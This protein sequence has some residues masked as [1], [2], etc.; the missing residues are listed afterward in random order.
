[1]KNLL[2]IL[3]L[4]SFGSYI[5][6]QQE[7]YSEV[8]IY[9]D[10]KSLADLAKLG[11]AVEEGQYLKGTYFITILSGKELKKITSSGFRYDILQ[12]DY[13]NFI[14]KRNQGSLQQIKE[15]NINKR[16]LSPKSSSNY[17]VPQG[18][19]LGSMGG[20]YTLAEANA[21]LDSLS[22]KYPNLCAARM[23]ATL[24][25][26]IEGRPV[27]YV[28]ISKDTNVWEN[29]PKILYDGLT[30]SREPI[31]MQELFFYVNY[32][33]E[34]YNTDPEIQYMIDNSEIYFIPVVNPDGY[35]Y[36][37]Y[38]E[39]NG[40][41]MWRKNRRNNGG[42]Q[43]G[44]DLNRNFGFKW[45]YDNIGSSPDSSTDTYRG[46]TAFSEPETQIIRDFCT[47][48]HISSALNDHSYA[49]VF[50]Y[51]W[52]Y[53]TSDTPDSLLQENFSKVMVQDNQLIY[54]TPGAVLYNTNGDANDWMYGDQTL[55]PKIFAFTPEI[56][57]GNDGFWPS[58]DDIIPLC[59]D[60]M[61]MNL[62]ATKLVLKYAQVMDNSP[63]I[64]A[65][66]QGYI[67]FQIER[68]GLDS[69]GIYNVSIQSLD[70]KIIPTGSARIFQNM[71][72]FQTLTD[73]ISYMLVPGITNGTTIR[74]L[75]QVNNGYYT[76]SDTIT[77]WYGTPIT[78]FSDSCNNLNNWISQQW[79]IT[80]IS[81]HTPP[82]CITDS[83]DGNYPNDDNNSIFMKDTVGLKN[84]PVAVLN[85]WARWNIERQQ[86]YLQVKIS[87]DNGDTWNSLTGRYTHN[88]SIYQVPGSPVYDGVQNDWVQEQIAL[89]NYFNKDI[90]IEFTLVSNGIN[91]AD[92]FYFDDI[93]VSIIDMPNGIPQIGGTPVFYL[94]D[95]I[96]NPSEKMVK[97]IYQL[98]PGTNGQFILFDTGGRI[99]K[100]F[101]L[102]PGSSQVIFSVEDF[103]A[104]LYYYQ[105]KEQTGFSEV[106]KIIVL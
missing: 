33:L 5:Y 35:E 6:A 7:K 66:K 53:I 60:C 31:G 90:R 65:S 38:I 62:M 87:D 89:T 105:V 37:H 12:D 52:S 51:P 79:G 57:D 84:S 39:P 101:N 8:K 56:G 106:K 19:S 67:K 47:L 92:G 49:G 21:E 28:K 40:G 25:N 20:F 43:Y 14:R 34:N 1:V 55:K 3:F 102:S 98:S 54:G 58:P 36:N 30:H 81:F 9:L 29:K 104:G 11:I 91:T 23:P 95:P 46:T 68:E 17:P 26:T 27:Y 88:G 63:V 2:I 103:N 94:A 44:V 85:F 80:T 75:L 78:V 70:G 50:L 93:N 97:V 73:S 16:K 72:L 48:H 96:P 69:T 10:S 99:L 22:I 83:P 64:L 61:L 45:G 24:T 15:I 76:H 86:D 32:L 82:S 4:L 74:Y 100:T 13:S 18:F 59:Q 71:T 77:K 41:G 42:G